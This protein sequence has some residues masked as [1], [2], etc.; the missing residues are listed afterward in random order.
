M[1]G[2]QPGCRTEPIHVAF[3]SYLEATRSAS[4]SGS[5]AE[6]GDAQVAAAI[7]DLERV[8]RAEAAAHRDRHAGGTELLARWTP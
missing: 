2:D 4:G 8:V 6:T 5:S 3:A 7:A 1:G